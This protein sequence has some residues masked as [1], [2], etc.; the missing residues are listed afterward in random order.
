MK[1]FTA[2][3]IRA[4]DAYTIAHEPVSSVELME[5]AAQQLGR[6]IQLKYQKEIPFIFFIGPGNNGG[7]GWALARILSKKGYENISVCLLNISERLSSDSEKNRKRLLKETQVEIKEID[8]PA[9]FPPIGPNDV[10]IDAIFG[11]GLTRPVKGLAARLIKHINGSARSAVIA[12]DIPSGLFAGENSNNTGDIIR[13]DTTLSFQF[14]KLSFFFAENDEY[15]GKWFV[16]PIGIHPKFIA[17]ENTELN[18]IHEDEVGALI[19]PRK[20]F[21]HKGSFGHALLIAGSYGMMGAAVLAARAALRSGAGLVTSHVPRMAVDIMQSSV[22]EA[23]LSIDES[24][25]IFTA[26]PPP[27]KF[28]A[29]GIGPGLDQ[30]TNTRKA[31]T[32]LLRECKVPLVIDADAL[33]LLSTLDNWQSS[34][35][36]GSVLTPHPKEF[37]RLF[38]VFADS[39]SRMKAQVAFSKKMECTIV[40]KQAH[41]CITLPDGQVW[42]NTTGNPGMA[43]GGSG[44]VLT[45]L[46]TG[47]LAQGYPAGEASLLG[48]FAHGLAGD[49]ACRDTHINAI[50]ASDITDNIGAAF[51]VIE[52]RKTKL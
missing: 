25:I 33:N 31:L 42:F 52:E 20:K 23:L 14:P 51:H 4:A 11:S 1:F 7:D 21:S 29:V 9:D 43:T 28:T 15:I 18:Y 44:D 19:R 3:K 30:K 49:I 46:I 35:P 22:P 26:P 13:A 50:I 2:D 27:D 34:V 32:T 41:T 47:L 8:S 24:D 12:I 6:W 36:Q 38:G 39:Y 5:R 48:V 10:V 40:L 45:G 37:E 17:H 16:L